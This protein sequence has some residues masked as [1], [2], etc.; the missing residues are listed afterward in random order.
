MA[1]AP[2]LI[3]LEEAVEDLER[4]RVFLAR[5][6]PQAARRAAKRIKNAAA[7]LRKYPGLGRP[8]EDP[9]GFR[10]LAAA[11]GAGAYILR[12]R[13]TAEGVV[14]VRVWHSRE[15]RR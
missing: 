9:P 8:V 3:W 7:M 12:Y 14:V 15:E 10:D 5:H 1:K 6:S 13:E 4:L 2:R 11:F